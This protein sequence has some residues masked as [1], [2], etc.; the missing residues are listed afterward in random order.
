[1]FIY[2]VVAE[3][4]SFLEGLVPVSFSASGLSVSIQGNSYTISAFLTLSIAVKELWI[5]VSRGLGSICSAFRQDLNK[6]TSLCKS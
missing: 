1:M 2:L 4:A 6:N 5:N 3:S